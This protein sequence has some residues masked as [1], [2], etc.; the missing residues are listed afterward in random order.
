MRLKP[1][2]KL[3]TLWM[4]DEGMSRQYNYIPDHVITHGIWET[5]GVE[6]KSNGRLYTMMCVYSSNK[7]LEVG[8]E[9]VMH[10]DRV[11]HLC[12]QIKIVHLPKLNVNMKK[13]N[14]Y[15]LNICTVCSVRIHNRSDHS[16]IC[17][18]CGHDSNSTVC[19]T[20]KVIIRK[21]KHDKPWWMIWKKRKVT[22]EG[23]NDLC[24]KWLITVEDD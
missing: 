19:Q 18:H 20:D 3:L 4:L 22:Y 12:H 11:I 8:K 7:L 21:I 2:I 13:G 15:S 9:I 1:Q 6:K 16:G 14:W 10:E 5:R 23:K 24:K 17:P